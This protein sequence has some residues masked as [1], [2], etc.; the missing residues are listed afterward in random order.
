MIG[1]EGKNR[2]VYS[3]YRVE[4]EVGITVLLPSFGETCPTRLHTSPR[5]AL[6]PHS[7]LPPAC[8]QSLLHHRRYA[9]GSVILEPIVING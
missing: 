8:I 4:E 7:N 6:T 1:H 2:K 3:K 9:V 5:Q